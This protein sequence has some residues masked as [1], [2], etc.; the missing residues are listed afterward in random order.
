MDLLVTLLGGTVHVPR[1]IF[2]PDEDPAGIATLLSEFAK[3][4][5]YWGA[6]TAQEG[7]EK[8]SRLRALRQR[9]DID[10]IDLDPDELE[11]FSEL[12]EG[13]YARMLG[14]ALPLGAGE[15]AVVAV[16]AGRGWD[17]VMDDA[18]GRAA[19]SDRVRNGRVMTC[20]ELLRSGVASSV[21]ESPEAEL[22]YMDL[23]AGR[24]SGPENLWAN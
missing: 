12:Q 11:L 13:P 20:R 21:L 10:V 6:S 18:A 1:A 15:A 4:E 3:A 9:T 19:F 23:L 14:F 22:V 7:P 2:D 24:L 17:A 5:R 16:A 8:A